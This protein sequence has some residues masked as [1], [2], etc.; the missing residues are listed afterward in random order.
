MMMMISWYQYL[1]YLYRKKN[2]DIYSYGKYRNV[3]KRIMCVCHFP[4][5]YINDRETRCLSSRVAVVFNPLQR[6]VNLDTVLSSCV[7]YIRVY[8]IPTKKKYIYYNRYSDGR[9]EI[10]GPTYQDRCQIFR[11]YNGLINV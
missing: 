8:I 9:T 10:R 3:L 7:F 11:N 1:K 4:L 6:S 5:F 2:I